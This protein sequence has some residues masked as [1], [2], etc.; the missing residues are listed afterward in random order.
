MMRAATDRA[1]AA[2]AAEQHGVVDRVDLTRLELD[3]RGIKRRV[4]GGFLHHIAGCP[5]VW[6]VGHAGLSNEG[7]V[8]A[9]VRACGPH[10]YVTGAHGAWLWDLRPPW[11]P[12]PVG[13]VSVVVARDCGRRPTA[14]SRCRR[15]LS[16]GE[17][18]LRRGIPVVSVERLVT[19][20]GAVRDLWTTER[21]MDRAIVERRTS[22]PSLEAHLE[23][24]RGQ[25]GA[26]ALRLLLAAEHRYAGLTRSELEEAFLRLLRRAGIELPRVNVRLGRD[27][28]DALF[29]LAG[30]V[31]E[32]DGT[33]WHR[34][35]ARQEA[36]R[37]KELRLRARGL[38]V[39]RYTARQVFEEP[40]SVL[41]DLVALLTVRSAGGRAV[42]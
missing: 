16:P 17:V 12:H 25:R 18:Q 19:D 9:A 10:T 35:R 39:V 1:I 15:D 20:V 42:A 22:I 2:R 23:R 24:V 27:L 38:L 36:D 31:V 33:S 28:L 32:L 8:L 3:A 14:T 30:L 37:Q 41:A 40:E 34:S 6:A 11:L 5:D 7:L 21:L 13:P 4:N 29:E 26:A